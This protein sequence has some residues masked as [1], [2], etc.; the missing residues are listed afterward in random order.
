MNFSVFNFSL[1]P[2]LN[3]INKLFICVTFSCTT[4]HL[5]HHGALSA[6]SLKAR[7]SGSNA[8]CTP[9]SPSLEKAGKTLLKK[10]IPSSDIIKSCMNRQDL[11]IREWLDRNLFA[12]VRVCARRKMHLYLDLRWHYLYNSIF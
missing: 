8:P 6:V 11:K 5:R 2:F 1:L 4:T 7:E 10:R 12:Q 9:A 3:S